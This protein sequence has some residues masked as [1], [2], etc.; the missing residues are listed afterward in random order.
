MSTLHLLTKKS[1]YAI[2]RLFADEVATTPSPRDID[3]MRIEVHL[4][5]HPEEEGQPGGGEV[6]AEEGEVEA[7]AV[8]S[9]KAGPQEALPA[10]Q[11][12]NRDQANNQNVT[13]TVSEERRAFTI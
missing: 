1:V 13:E 8:K 3:A 9:A 5:L 7:G 4:V 12:G 2:N 6:E 11:A 10:S